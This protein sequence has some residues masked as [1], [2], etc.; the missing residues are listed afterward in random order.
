MKLVGDFHILPGKSIAVADG[1]EV[2]MPYLFLHPLLKDFDGTQQITVAPSN[3]KEAHILNGVCPLDTDEDD[4]F[5]LWFCLA[6]HNRFRVQ[7][8]LCRSAII[9]NSG[10]WGS[11]CIAICRDDR[12]SEIVF[13]KGLTVETARLECG[14]VVRTTAQRDCI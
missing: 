13:H 3:H 7:R 2:Y 6:S 14:V 9:L 11:S 1:T 5:Y 10:E 12:P 8:H 4:G